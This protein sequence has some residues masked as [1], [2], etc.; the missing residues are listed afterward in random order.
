MLKQ[1]LNRKM[2]KSRSAYI[3]K[4]QRD[5]KSREYEKRPHFIFIIQNIKIYSR[6]WIN[7]AYTHW[8][9]LRKTSE[10]SRAGVTQLSGYIFSSTSPHIVR[11]TN[12]ILL[13]W[14]NFINFLFFFYIPE[15]FN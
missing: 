3:Y 6:K 1:F 7:D 5:E 14:T 9:D 11:V 12:L 13:Y 15:S 10:G 8:D 4:K 2:E